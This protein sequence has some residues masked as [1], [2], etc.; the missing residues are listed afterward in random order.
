[1]LRIK[2]LNKKNHPFTNK[3]KLYG[4]SIET[5]L[6]GSFVL[7]VLLMAAYY[8]QSHKNKKQAN[9]HDITTKRTHSN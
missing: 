4:V 3:I 7:I 9:R 1:M 2:V 8:L 5:I 6:I